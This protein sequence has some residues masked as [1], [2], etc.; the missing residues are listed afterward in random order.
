MLDI[1]DHAEM[2]DCMPY[3]TLVDT[4]TKLSSSGALVSDV[5]HYCHLAGALQYLT[6]TRPDIV[7]AVQ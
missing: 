6:L 4:S 2:A 3:S 5:T 1:L 7:Y